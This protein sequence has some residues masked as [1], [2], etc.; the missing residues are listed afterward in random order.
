MLCASSTRKRSRSPAMT[1]T[2]CSKSLGNIVVNPHV[3]PSFIDFEVGLRLRVNGRASVHYEDPVLA[4]FAGAQLMVR[5]EADTVFPNCPR[6]IHKLKFV[7]HSVHAPRPE[8]TPPVPDWKRRPEYSEALPPNDPARPENAQPSGK[9]LV[10]E[11][12]GD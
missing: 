6:Y 8:H 5:V 4:E 2:V 7:E 9:P 11:P 3:G 12:K 1:A 10:P